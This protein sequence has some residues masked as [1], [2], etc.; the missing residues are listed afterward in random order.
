MRHNYYYKIIFTL[1]LA[2]CFSTMVGQT[3]K[4]ISHGVID[5]QIP[6]EWK[7]IKSEGDYNYIYAD[8]KQSPHQ[9]FSLIEM[10]SNLDFNDFV[11]NVF[12]PSVSMLFNEQTVMGESQNMK[13]AGGDAI[14]KEVVR[15]N[16]FGISAKGYAYGFVTAKKSYLLF[17]LH[18]MAHP[19][20]LQKI[21]D[22]IK[23]NNTGRSSAQE[24]L[25]AWMSKF[26]S[27]LPIKFKNG[28]LFYEFSLL[29]DG[30]LNIGLRRESIHISTLSEKSLEELRASLAESMSTNIFF[31]GIGEDD[32]WRYVKEGH[33]VYLNVVDAQNKTIY[34]NH[35]SSKDLTGE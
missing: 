7:L 30:E 19:D 23:L 8:N 26:Q 18:A 15:D 34:S 28:D 14:R 20:V 2:T 11:E 24:D 32:V 22:S 27:H 3:F 9:I 29:D 10:P 33:G 4:T 31:L 21:I 6:S 1:M 13:I 12:N 35:Y 25:K 16:S 5:L 17:Y